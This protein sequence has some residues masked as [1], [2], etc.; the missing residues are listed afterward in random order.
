MLAGQASLFGGGAPAIDARL[1]GLRR[2]WL[3]DAAWIDH[4]PGWVSGHG[5]LMDALAAS[6]R[7]HESE[8]KMYDRIVEVPRVVASLPDD[9]PGHPV[10]EQ[11][12]EAL[13]AHYGTPFERISLGYYRN[14][15]D[16]VA[17]HGD[18][19]AREMEEALVAT[20]SVGE[21]R[22]FFLRPASGGR[23]V[24]FSL[25]W[26]DLI[27][28][29]GTCQRTWQHSIPKVAHADPRIAIMFRPHWAATSGRH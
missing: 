8:R 9:G 28:M 16:S 6:T 24:A 23:S 26:G 11:A 4:L 22:R 5:T 10:I 12:R 21:P 27:V 29:G 7:W 25:G 19:V 13:S 20:V 3:D 2:V 17:W 1:A 14:G 18:Y 15:K